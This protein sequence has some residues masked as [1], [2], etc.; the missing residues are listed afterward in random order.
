MAGAP[1]EAQRV[2][3]PHSLRGRYMT[4]LCSCLITQV[5]DPKT[6]RAWLPWTDRPG[7]WLAFYA[8][9]CPAIGEGEYGTGKTKTERHVRREV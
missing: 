9:F 3:L 5:L 4:G 2:A 1:E 8:I 7:V 6:L